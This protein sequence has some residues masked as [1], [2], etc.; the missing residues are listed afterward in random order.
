MFSWMKLKNV[1]LYITGSNSKM[2]SSDIITE[3]RDRGDEVRVYPLSYKEFY[4]SF[5]GNKNRV[6]RE[7]F[8]YG[9]M[10]LAATKK[11]PEEKKQISSGSVYRHLYQRCT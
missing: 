2:L 1:D 5:E 7:Y 6:W 9:G 11:T 10:P 3:F 8:T 4:D